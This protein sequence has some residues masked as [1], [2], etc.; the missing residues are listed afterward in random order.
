MALDLTRMQILRFVVIPQALRVIV[1][2]LGSQ[3]LNVVKIQRS[4]L[5]LAIPIWSQS[6]PEPC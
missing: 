5:R 2:P 3:F 4:R 1:P 6:L